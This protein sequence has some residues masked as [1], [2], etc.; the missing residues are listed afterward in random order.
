[1]FPYIRWSGGQTGRGRAP[2][3]STIIRPPQPHRK[4]PRGTDAVSAGFG[5]TLRTAAGGGGGGG[6]IGGGAGREGADEQT[7]IS[8]RLQARTDPS[9]PRNTPALF[10][11]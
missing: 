5:R 10:I 3:V 6:A 7:P 9:P 4:R 2:S 8:I 1:L 11:P